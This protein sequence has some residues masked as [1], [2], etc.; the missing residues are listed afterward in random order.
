MNHEYLNNTLRPNFKPID[1]NNF[2]PD[3]IKMRTKPPT[4]MARKKTVTYP[5]DEQDK[6]VIESYFKAVVLEEN[7][8]CVSPQEP[9]QFT[10]SRIKVLPNPLAGKVI[11]S[12]I[13]SI[14]QGAVQ[15][16]RAD[17][18]NMTELV[19]ARKVLNLYHGLPFFTSNLVRKI[20]GINKRQSQYYMKVL[21]TCN[22]LL[23]T[24]RNSLLQSSATDIKGT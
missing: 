17:S 16:Y 3:K 20:M 11:G 8:C 12:D 5:D 19:S 24:T 15:S 7:D 23:E 18:S 1:L 6:E 13:E 14:I 10:D 22:H 4:W 9:P 2:D 21:G